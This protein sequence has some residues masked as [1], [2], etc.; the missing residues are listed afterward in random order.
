MEPLSI[1]FKPQDRRQGWTSGSIYTYT[2]V[3]ACIIC[4]YIRIDAYLTT[5]PTHVYIYM[6]LY[7]CMYI[8]K[9]HHI[10]CKYIYIHIYV[11]YVYI[12]I[13]IFTYT[14][15]YIYIYICMYIHM[16]I[17]ARYLGIHVHWGLGHLG[18]LWGLTR[19]TP[20]P[21]AAI[22]PGPGGG[23]AWAPARLPGASAKVG[24]P[25]RPEGSYYCI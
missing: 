5:Y 14:L 16:Y 11:V 24:R 6:Y 13:Y 1:Q 20:T 17:V 22:C 23:L 8:Y 21:K 19:A 4:M 7:T 12:Y 18:A 10:I 25:Q 15:V 9:R 3:Y 2:Y